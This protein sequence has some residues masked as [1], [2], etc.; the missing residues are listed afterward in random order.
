[1]NLYLINQ[2]RNGDYDSFD[3]AV[4]VA[5]SSEHAKRIHPDGSGTGLA[6]RDTTWVSNPSLVTATFIGT[7][8][9]E[10]KAGTVIVSSFNAG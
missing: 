6:D 4:V 9:K 10:L 3:S 7:A 5:E 8:E 2:D 1:M